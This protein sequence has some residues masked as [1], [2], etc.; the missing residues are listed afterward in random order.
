MATDKIELS[1][2]YSIFNEE[3]WIQY[4]IESVYDCV[5][6][7]VIAWGP[8]KCN[9]EV[10]PDNTRRIIKNL[11]D[12]DKKILLLEGQYNSEHEQRNACLNY[13]KSGY[14]FL[15]DAD[16]IYD[17]KVMMRMKK[18][19]EKHPEVYVFKIPSLIF[20]RNFDTIIEGEFNFPRVFKVLPE[21][22]FTWL[23]MMSLGGTEYEVLGQYIFNGSKIF[24]FHFAY[25]K[26]DKAMY[27]K[28]RA[29]IERE[30]GTTHIIVRN[31]YEKVW[32]GWKTDPVSAFQLYGGVHPV[33]PPA[34]SSFRKRTETLPECLK[35]HPYNG[36]GLVE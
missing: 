27:E 30:D 23:N 16:E 26:S 10:P 7:I 12:P 25:A 28:I 33:D 34:F 15:V 22:S 29:C 20:W 21:A 31:W 36:L 14:Y 6:R 8:W 35:K 19:I 5:E 4:S 13:V 18:T 1:A 24:N 3:D 2:C 9:L 17:K 11:D 32:I